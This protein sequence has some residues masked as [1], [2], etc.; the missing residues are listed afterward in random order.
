VFAP[1]WIA[2]EAHRPLRRVEYEKL[3]Q[4]GAFDDERLELLYGSLIVTSPQ[5]PAH[6]FAIQKLNR[7]LVR[8]LSDRADVR[9]QSA[10]AAGDDSEP[11][12]DVAV[13]P[14]G[15]IARRIRQKLYCWSR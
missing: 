6:D 9:I 1:D 15:D 10:F 8:A 5:G 7:I 11:Q 4:L 14:L 13:V 3:A 2:P 12:P